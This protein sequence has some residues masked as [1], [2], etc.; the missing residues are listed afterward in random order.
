MTPTPTITPDASSTPTITP[1]P[2][3][4]LAP[5][6]LGGGNDA[7]TTIA[8]STATSTIETKMLVATSTAS[9]TSQ[10]WRAKYY[11]YDT[12]R[13]DMAG[14]GTPFSDI[15]G[16]DPGDP[17][18][19]NWTKDWFSSTFFRKEETQSRIDF[20][21][22]FTP[23]AGNT[24]PTTDPEAYIAAPNF[25]AHFM[26][27]ATVDTEGDYPY[28]LTSDGDAWFYL[29]GTL[30]NRIQSGIKPAATV[31]GTKH[32]VPGQHYVVHLFFTERM[33]VYPTFLFRF[34]GVTIVPCTDEGCTPPELNPD[35]TGPT[36]PVITHSTH[37]ANATSSDPSVTISWTDSTD[38]NVA[39]A[40]TAGLAGYSFDWTRSP[41]SVPAPPVKDTATTTTDTL[42]DGTWWFHVVAL[43]NAGNVSSPVTTYGPIIIASSTTEASFRIINIRVTDVTF[44]SAIIHW[45][46]VNFDDT[47]HPAD[48]RVI[49]D[50][51]SHPDIS[52]AAAPNFSYTSSTDTFDADPKVVEHAVTVTGLLPSTPYYFRVISQ[53][54]PMVIS[55]EFSNGT[56]DNGGGGGGGGIS[57]TAPTIL[58]STIAI[59]A[60]SCTTTEAITW[61]ASSVTGSSSLAGYSFVWDHQA[62][63]VPDNT[64][65]TT[66]A[67][68]T[69][70]FTQTLTPGTW[71]FHIK[72]LDTNGDV[73]TVTN[74]GPIIINAA[75]NCEGGFITQPSP[76]PTPTPTLGGG[77]GGSGGSG[78]G[79]GYVTTPT[80]T[81]LDLP[82]N[83]Q[84]YLRKFIH[85]GW[86]NDPVEVRKLQSFLKDFEGFSNLTVDG[87]Y[88]QDDYEA[89]KVFQTRYSLDVLN[90]WGISDPT[91]FVFITTTLKIN[92]LYCGVSNRI[93]LNL[94]NYYPAGDGP[95]YQGLAVK[96]P[97]EVSGTS[98]VLAAATTSSLSA[99][100]VGTTTGAGSRFQTAALAF[101]GTLAKPWIWIPLL[102]LVVLAILWNINR[103]S[104]D[105]DPDNDKDEAEIA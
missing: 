9:S 15:E 3:P 38:P 68:L 105:N 93:T 5:D 49:Y 96:P 88:K 70:S 75:G 83:C 95:S 45:T 97:S 33:A 16:I 21:D 8:T 85:L 94:R 65:D 79:G 1:T 53:G 72:A 47:G 10:I 34:P 24:D 103:E 42:S 23:F 84:P 92:Y 19:P 27:I 91:G 35:T 89:V 52:Q 102:L 80:P 11:L 50:T 74:Y 81:P 64:V 59:N 57:V 58:S 66:D 87:V 40:I 100:N 29:G 60:P 69:T 62:G 104:D 18:S 61:S 63:T 90:P 67:G 82:A 13:T 36:S 56:G 30:D 12:P 48:S 77:G 44:Q 41:D 39:G 51:V 86:D 20:G 6:L 101:L 37:Q 43:D 71:F 54:S 73:S 76:T 32:L 2:T 98:T 28:T 17:L 25:G 99:G 7:S 26:G 78:G 14:W 4:T 46:T 22:H 55:G 31:T